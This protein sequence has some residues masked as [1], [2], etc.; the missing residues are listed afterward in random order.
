MKLGTNIHH[1][2]GHCWKGIQGQRSKVKVI[3]RQMHF[4]RLSNKADPSSARIPFGHSRE[5]WL[6][7]INL[8]CHLLLIQLIL[9]TVLYP[10]PDF[11]TFCVIYLPFLARLYPFHMQNIET[12]PI[13]NSFPIVLRPA[14]RPLS[15]Q[16][17]HTDRRCGVKADLL[18]FTVIKESVFGW[19]KRK[20]TWGVHVRVSECASQR[21]I[22]MQFLLASAVEV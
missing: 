17:R 15:V 18:I 4:C 9:Y 19:R 1:V 3:A 2:R 11:I 8:L 16:R 13:R 20:M 7:S 6:P 21:H 10:L 14:I 5:D 12:V 22:A